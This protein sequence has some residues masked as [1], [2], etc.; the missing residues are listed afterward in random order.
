MSELSLLMRNG[1]QL[2]ALRNLDGS[3]DV[4]V[5]DQ[6]GELLEAV[7]LPEGEASD[8]I[9]K[10]LTAATFRLAKTCATCGGRFH[11]KRDA[12]RYCSTSCKLRASRARK[13][14]S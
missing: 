14:A 10:A 3:L 1:N 6:T 12:A 9:E 13:A 8:A 5:T 2:D 7:T 4:H 11:A